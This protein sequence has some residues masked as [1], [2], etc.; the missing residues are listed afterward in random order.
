MDDERPISTEELWRNNGAI[1]INDLILTTEAKTEGV[2]IQADRNEV[3]VLADG[4][5]GWSA[6]VP[7]WGRASF[8]FLASNTCLELAT[9]NTASVRLQLPDGA[10]AEASAG[11][12]VRFDLFNDKSY[13]V[14]GRG[15]VSAHSADGK[16]VVMSPLLPAL[17]GGPRVF[18]AA[19]PGAA[20]HQRVSP[21]IT[22]KIQGDPRGDLA[23]H[24]GTQTIKLADANQQEVVFPNGSILV[25]KQNRRVGYLKWQ[26]EKGDFRFNLEGMAGWTAC[27]L[28]GEAA[29]LRWDKAT[30]TIDINNDSSENSIVV[31]LPNATFARLNPGS[32]FQF[33]EI[34][35]LTFA[36][37]ARGGVVLF[38]A[39][40]GQETQ[41]GQGNLMFKSTPA[42]TS[43]KTPARESAFALN[44]KSDD[45]LDV[46][47]SSGTIRV[48]IRSEKIVPGSEQSQLHVQ[49]R[50]A[51][52]I[53]LRSLLGDCT[54]HPNAVG[55]L[56]IELTEGNSLLLAISPQHGTLTGRALTGNFSPVTLALSDRLKLQLQPDESVTLVSPSL[57]WVRLLS[58]TTPVPTRI[59]V[60]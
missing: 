23:V 46:T 43:R 10:V 15:K 51:G 25:L 9:H 4:F 41:L 44:W 34:N 40:T 8:C 59:D 33:A 52:R 47:S 45:S 32:T 35:R 24:A 21:T 17:T 30:Q 38:N 13:T 31:V 60:R 20:S 28:T 53:L 19:P 56:A 49:F 1:S 27:G 2:T 58:S 18:A 6:T 37:A 14:S 3:E 5:D 39:R 57:N 22:V 7:K 26:V 54:I 11:S 29:V 50:E 36:T 48:R 42:V 16:K 55:N 12:S